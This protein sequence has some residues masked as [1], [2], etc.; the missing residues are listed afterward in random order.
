MIPQRTQEKQ[1]RNAY[2]INIK[3]KQSAQ[4]LLHDSITDYGNR[5][6]GY[7]WLLF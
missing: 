3:R 1:Y 2:S 7:E 6:Q 5:T 4:G